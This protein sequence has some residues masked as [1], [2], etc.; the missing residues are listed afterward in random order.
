ADAWVEITKYSKID[1]VVSG[2]VNYSGNGTSIPTKAD[3]T[4]PTKPTPEPEP[5]T[6]PPQTQTNPGVTDNNS[7]DNI[8]TEEDFFG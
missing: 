6:E 7:G 2:G 1:F 3:L 5:E 4:V 8:F